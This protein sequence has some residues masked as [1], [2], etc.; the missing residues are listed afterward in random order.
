MNILLLTTILSITSCLLLG[1]YALK[2]NPKDHANRYFA[3]FCF[4]TVLWLIFSYLSLAEIATNIFVVRITMVLAVAQSAALLLFVLNFSV[5]KYSISFLRVYYGFGI[6][7]ALASAFPFVFS[8]MEVMNGFLVPVAGPGMPIF[9]VFAVGSVTAAIILLMLNMWKV[10]R[11]NRIRTFYIL[12]GLFITMGL[13]IISNFFLIVLFHSL[14]LASLG[15]MS[16]LFFVGFTTFAMTRYRFLDVKVIFSKSVVYGGAIVLLSGAYLC[17]AIATYVF[18][19]SH[20]SI[21]IA[22]PAIFFSALYV[23]MVQHIST[24]IKRWLDG[25][26]FRD[27]IDLAKLIHEENLELNTTHELEFFVLKLAGS[28]Q[29]VSKAKVQQIFILQKRYSRLRSFFPQRSQEVIHFDDPLFVEIQKNKDAYLYDELQDRNLGKRIRKLM[30]NNKA[31]IYLPVWSTDD[32][33]AIILIGE[34]K[35]ASSFDPKDIVA[36][37]EFQKTAAE[38]IPTLLYWQT[39]IE[40]LREHLKS[41]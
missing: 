14:S 34:H 36:L 10:D 7:A 28:I 32:L 35:N 19:D 38:S 40:N 31:E 24:T 20:F 8:R 15:L 33:L 3:A 41:Q 4:V 12:L 22:L 23:F 13:V 11:I 9:A 18:F 26:F 6:I 21:D 16:V 17:T 1:L 37:E 27:E 29:Q 25:L 2:F 39:T 30:K 5:F